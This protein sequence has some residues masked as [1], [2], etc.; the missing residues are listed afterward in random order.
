MAKD[1]SSFNHSHPYRALIQTFSFAI[2]FYSFVYSFMILF[3]FIV[4]FFSL[5]FPTSSFLSFIFS[6]LQFRSQIMSVG[7]S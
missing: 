4:F 5:L 2:R 6:F 1:P 3:V 7:L